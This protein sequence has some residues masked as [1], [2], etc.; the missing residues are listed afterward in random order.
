M[1]LC[2]YKYILTELSELVVFDYGLSDIQ[3]G[4]RCLRNGIYILWLISSSCV[5]RT[6]VSA[7]GPMG[8]LV[9]YPMKMKHLG[10][11]EIKLFDFHEIFKNPHTFIH[12][13]FISKTPGS[14][15]GARDQV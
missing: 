2:R 13:K 4:L 9:K 8:P 11:S 10:L 14:T 6:Q 1:K 5:T 15:P 3:D 12:V 7:S